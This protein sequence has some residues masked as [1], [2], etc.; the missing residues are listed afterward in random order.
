MFSLIG[1]SLAVVV[2]VTRS[3]GRILSRTMTNSDSH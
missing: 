1:K 2:G 3:L